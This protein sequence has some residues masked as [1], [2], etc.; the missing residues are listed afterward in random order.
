MTFA[1]VV[2]PTGTAATVR[3]GGSG[4]PGGECRGRLARRPTGTVFS[5]EALH[6][7]EGHLGKAEAA[8]EGEAPN[9]HPSAPV[10]LGAR[11]PLVWVHEEGDHVGGRSVR[12]YPA[13]EPRRG[14]FTG[15]PTGTAT[16]VVGETA[17]VE[18]GGPYGD[19]HFE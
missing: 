10:F 9:A 2:G 6:L 8:N 16:P 14:L 18:K 19:G 13:T 12:A 11:S 4:V 15:T 17:A 7:R 3:E 1:I 5:P